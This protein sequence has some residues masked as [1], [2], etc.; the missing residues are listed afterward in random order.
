M[1]KI[2][3]LDIVA[4]TEDLEATHF[5][6]KQIIKLYKGQV[7]TVVME[8]DGSAFEVE[9]SHQD[10]TTYAMETILATKLMLLHYELVE[11]VGAVSR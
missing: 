3:D 1:K 7:G 11:S 9:F 10:G 2:K 4:L 6:T 8:F 5:E